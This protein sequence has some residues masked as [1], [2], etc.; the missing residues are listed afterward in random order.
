M[1]FNVSSLYVRTYISGINTLFSN[2]HVRISHVTFGYIYMFEAHI[3][4]TYEY[5]WAQL[6]LPNILVRRLFVTSKHICRELTCYLQTYSKLTCYFQTYMSKTH[7]LL[8]Y[9]YLTIVQDFDTLI[10]KLVWL[11]ASMLLYCRDQFFFHGTQE[12]FCSWGTRVLF[13][14]SCVGFLF[15]WVLYDSKNK[16]D[17]I[18]LEIICN[19]FIKVKYRKISV[20]WNFRFWGICVNQESVWSKTVILNR[21]RP[22][23]H[24]PQSTKTRPIRPNK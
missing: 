13:S 8:S 19:C 15:E 1:N 10:N 2:I 4:V 24:S 17:C 16:W 3:Y 12:G 18:I 23:P 9:M 5:T 6:L 11:I 7:M 21:I 22:H 20:W 14:S